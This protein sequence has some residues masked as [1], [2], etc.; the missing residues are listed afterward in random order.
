MTDTLEIIVSVVGVGAVLLVA[1]VGVDWRLADRLRTMEGRLD[2]RLE[3]VEN[4][5]GDMGAGIR[6]LNQQ[7]ASIVGLL[8]T[9]FMFLHRSKAISD[10]EYY[11]TIGQF[12][13]LLSEATEPLVDRLVRDVNPL[14]GQEARRFRELVEKARRGEFFSHPEVQ[15]YNSLIRKVRNERP[16]DPSIWPLVALGAFLLGLYLGRRPEDA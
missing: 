9:A 2:G 4:R 1:L 15:E 13:S 5:V 3:R 8:P 7:V 11:Q 6:S 14:T 12:T 10:E 16:D